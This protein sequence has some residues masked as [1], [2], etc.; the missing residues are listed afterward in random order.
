MKRGPRPLLRSG[1]LA[2]AAAACSLAVPPGRA[3]DKK[4][5]TGAGQ[6]PKVALAVP[7]AVARGITTKV[8]LRGLHLAGATEV[9]V[10]G[11]AAGGGAEAGKA[12]W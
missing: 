7:L 9:R 4:P 5:D 12:P 10:E 3:E 1:A 6:P 2:L 11:P 8:L